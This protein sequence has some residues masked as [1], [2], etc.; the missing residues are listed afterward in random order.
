M[1]EGVLKHCTEMNIDKQYVDSHGQ[2]LVAFAFCHLLGLDLMPRLKG[3]AYLSS[4]GWCRDT[5]KK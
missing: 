4:Q 1:I 3:I 2:S 5:C